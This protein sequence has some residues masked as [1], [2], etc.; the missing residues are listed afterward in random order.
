M[1]R[2]VK[3]GEV[4]SRERKGKENDK[5]EGKGRATHEVVAPRAGPSRA[6]S[7]KYPIP[8]FQATNCLFAPRP[9]FSKPWNAHL[10]PG[11]TGTQIETNYAATVGEHG[12]RENPSR[13][14]SSHLFFVQRS[15]RQE[16]Q[17]KEGATVITPFLPTGFSQVSVRKTGQPGPSQHDLTTLRHIKYSQEEGPGHISQGLTKFD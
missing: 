8:P 13:K 1:S 16:T 10:N 11:R 12:N 4:G 5:M 9:T 6:K 15:L 3:R 2:R 14:K 7:Q 17:N